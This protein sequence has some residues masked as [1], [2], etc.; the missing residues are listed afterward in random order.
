M[1]YLLRL[2]VRCVGVGVSF[3]RALSHVEPEFHA[4]GAVLDAVF[5][6]LRFLRC[7]DDGQTQP[8]TAFGA[9]VR[10]VRAIK[11][12]PDVRPSRRSGRKRP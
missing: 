1:I 12:G 3:S 6:L 11:A 4:V 2:L 9:G 7:G 10:F 5:H 8:E